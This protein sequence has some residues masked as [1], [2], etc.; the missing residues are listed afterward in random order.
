MRVF[1]GF[2]FIFGDLTRYRGIFGI[3]CLAHSENVTVS[4]S[5]GCNI[6]IYVPPEGRGAL[7]DDSRRGIIPTHTDMPC[8]PRIGPLT[9]T[10]GAYAGVY[11]NTHR[12]PA[13]ILV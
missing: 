9:A 6:D 12:H 10:V 5:I 11:P 13:I 1:G 2:L 3:K 7:L 4:A 8:I